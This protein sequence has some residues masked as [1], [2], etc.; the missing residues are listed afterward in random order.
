MGEWLGATLRLSAL[1][2]V[3]DRAHDL[4]IDLLAAACLM[5]TL[6]AS[7]SNKAALS[8]PFTQF[9]VTSTYTDWGAQMAKT[10]RS[11]IPRLQRASL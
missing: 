2:E 4:T 5:P 8:V 9:L 10:S 3:I 11:T 7:L 6:S 1:H